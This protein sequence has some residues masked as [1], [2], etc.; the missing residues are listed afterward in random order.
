MFNL[1]KNTRQFSEMVVPSYIYTEQ[2]LVFLILAIL[3]S[4]AWY[5]TVLL[6]CSFL[7]I[8]ETEHLPCETWLFTYQGFLV[9]T[10]QT[11]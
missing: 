8:D 3:V 7:M 1:V 5:V 6:I 2:N 11:F 10:V 9:V 4:M